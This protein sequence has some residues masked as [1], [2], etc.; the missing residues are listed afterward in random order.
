MGEG[1]DNQELEQKAK[2]SLGFSRFYLLNLECAYIFRFSISTMQQLRI[3]FQVFH[4]DNAVVTLSSCDGKFERFFSLSVGQCN[5]SSSRQ[6]KYKKH[7]RFIMSVGGRKFVPVLFIYSY[8]FV[9]IP[10]KPVTHDS[11]N[12]QNICFC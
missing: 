5:L 11:Q 1:G 3:Y 10:P 2:V 7:T 12:L 6:D 4:F 9:C 8:S